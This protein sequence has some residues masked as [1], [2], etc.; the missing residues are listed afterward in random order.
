MSKMKEFAQFVEDFAEEHQAKPTDRFYSDRMRMAQSL[1]NWA[2]DLFTD[3]PEM[4]ESYMGICPADFDELVRLQS[5]GS[6][7]AG[8]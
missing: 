1:E 3:N 7:C 5:P 8:E 4:L 2:L 6:G